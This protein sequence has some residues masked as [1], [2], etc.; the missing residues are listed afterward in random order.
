M[1]AASRFSRRRPLIPV[2]WAPYVFISPF[3]LLFGAFGLFPL[4]FSI[5]L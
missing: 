1:T 5:V 3:F 4:L 2:R